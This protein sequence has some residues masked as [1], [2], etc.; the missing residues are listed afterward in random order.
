MSF[1]MTNNVPAR[2]PLRV[3]DERGT[4]LIEALLT[5]VILTVS[6]T[7]MI[8]S[9]S[10]GLRATVFCRDYT[11]AALLA[12]NKMFELLAKRSLTA[13]LQEDGKFSP[14]E[15]FAYSLEVK[16]LFPADPLSQI[17]ESNLKIT[18]L[19]GMKEKDLTL[20]TYFLSPQKGKK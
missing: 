3:K 13:P 12:E 8:Y 4:L 6:V 15:N 18:W 17:Q 16:K 1:P 2:G 5:L 19:S 10:Q 14:D 20:A 11:K 7:V 9:L